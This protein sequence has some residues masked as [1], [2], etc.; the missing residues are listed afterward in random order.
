M[1]VTFH[2]KIT[3]RPGSVFCFGT[4]SSVADEEGTLRRIADPPRKKSPLANSEN[5]GV[6]KEKGATSSA[7]KKGRLQQARGRG[8]TDPENSPVYFTDERMDA[9]RKEERN[10]QNQE[11]ASCSFR[12]FA[13]KGERKEDRHDRRTLLPRRPLHRESGVAPRLRQRADRARRRTSSAGIPSTEEPT[14]KCP[15]TSQGRRAGPRAAC[16]VRRGLRDRGNSGGTRLQR[17]KELP[18]A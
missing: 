17:T 12:S 2:R 6:R 4:I 9:N 1:A 16:L 15:A 14:P 10:K 11:E 18:T 5:I 7:P 3:L 8:P 13:L